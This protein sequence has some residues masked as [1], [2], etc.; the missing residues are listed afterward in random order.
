MD[1]RFTERTY[2]GDY[3][4]VGCARRATHSSAREVAGFCVG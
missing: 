1:N 4:I 2:G 3:R